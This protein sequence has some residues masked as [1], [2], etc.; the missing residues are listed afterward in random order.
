[1]KPGARQKFLEANGINGCAIQLQAAHG[2]A[3]KRSLARLRLDHPQRE[4]RCGKLHRNRRRAT[5]GTEIQCHRIA[6]GEELRGQNRLQKQSVDRL[7]SLILNG[8]GSQGDLAVPFTKQLE[9]RDETVD[10]AQP[11]ATNRPWKRV[12]RAFRESALLF[13]IFQLAVLRSAVSAETARHTWRGPQ[14]RL[15]L[16]R[17]LSSPGRSSPAAPG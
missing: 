2:F 3:Q 4:L 8:Q 16:C 6:L 1:M 17:G 5:P 11:A 14:S 10:Y 13:R 12:W 9:V 15:G 7:V